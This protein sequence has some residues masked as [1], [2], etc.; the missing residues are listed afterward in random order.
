MENELI[1]GADDEPSKVD[2]RVSVN[3]TEKNTSTS[4]KI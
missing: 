1:S 3:F 2:E 4:K